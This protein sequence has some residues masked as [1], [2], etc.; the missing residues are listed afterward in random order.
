MVWGVW[1]GRGRQEE[2]WVVRSR[3]RIRGGRRKGTP[4]QGGLVEAS[5][6]G[7]VQTSGVTWAAS[8]WSPSEFVC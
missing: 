4:G 3:V 8:F 2:A 1:T 6:D 5:L 7:G